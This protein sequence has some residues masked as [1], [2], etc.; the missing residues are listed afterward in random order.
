MKTVLVIEDQRTDA[1][2]IEQ[3]LRNVRADIDVE[4]ATTLE[5]ATE[6]LAHRTFDLIVLDLGLTDSGGHATFAAVNLLS[7]KSP[8][9][10]LTVADDPVDRRR[11]EDAGVFW[12]FV[13]GQFTDDDF[14][15][16]VITA[17]GTKMPKPIQCP[18][19]DGSAKQPTLKNI[20]WM[21]VFIGSCAASGISV[22]L[23]ADNRYMFKGE[24]Q[25]ILLALYVSDKRNL[26]YKI[27]ELNS[28]TNKTDAQRLVLD[29]AKNQLNDVMES[30]RKLEKSK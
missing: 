17:I 15:D 20:V 29:L 19:D 28:L 5:A 3:K 22:Q 14:K 10:V 11:I 8:I 12:Y 4:I 18:I 27:I 13:K 2:I 1:A 7:N 26:E 6:K 25:Q 24:G 9:V 16:V 21:L 23:F 30:I